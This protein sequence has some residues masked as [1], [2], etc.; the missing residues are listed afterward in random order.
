MRSNLTGM[1]QMNA[2]ASDP[3]PGESM[4]SNEQMGWTIMGES[5]G[6]TGAGIDFTGI[7]MSDFLTVMEGAM[8][9]G[10][11]GA[12][13]GDEQMQGLFDIMFSNGMAAEDMSGLWMMSEE[14]AGMGQD[15]SWGAM[16]DNVSGDDMMTGGSGVA[17]DTIDLMGVDLQAD[18]M[19]SMMG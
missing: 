17:M 18:D 5:I 8:G 3:T 13:T 10:F 7:M 19:V 1:T 6:N 12:M 9:Q 15:G 4:E 14:N 16:G 11:F 2:A